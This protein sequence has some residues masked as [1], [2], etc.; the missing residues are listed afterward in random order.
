MGEGRQQDTADKVGM[1]WGPR[2]E[3]RILEWQVGE[4]AGGG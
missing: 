2:G 1:D 3:G 4:I